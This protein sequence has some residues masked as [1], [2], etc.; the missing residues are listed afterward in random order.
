ML[1]N[2]TKQIVKFVNL[3]KNPYK[4]TKEENIKRNDIKN[5]IE[6][7][8]GNVVYVMPTAKVL[9]KVINMNLYYHVGIISQYG[10]LDISE[11]PNRKENKLFIISIKNIDKFFEDKESFYIIKPK[12]NINIILKN[13]ELIVKHKILIKEPFNFKYNCEHF[14]WKYICEDVNFLNKHSQ[15]SNFC[16]TMKCFSESNYIGCLYNSKINDYDITFYKILPDINESS[17]R[18]YLSNFFICR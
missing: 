14:I 2:F 7:N 11:N 17:T 1:H 13:I 9:G 5:F 4:I 12:T 10:I 8:I 15:F 16:K 18:N 6:N 3:Y